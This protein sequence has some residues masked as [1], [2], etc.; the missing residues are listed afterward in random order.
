VGLVVEAE[1]HRDAREARG[2]AARAHAVGAASCRSGSTG[3]PN[4]QECTWLSL[5]PLKSARFMVTQ[6]DGE[7][8]VPF[9]MGIVLAPP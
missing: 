8:D 1:V 7:H 6:S 5:W 4:D 9:W 2:E 3:F